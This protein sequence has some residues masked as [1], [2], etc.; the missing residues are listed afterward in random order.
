MSG[1]NGSKAIQKTGKEK[2]WFL[3]WKKEKH[4]RIGI[5]GYGYEK[6]NNL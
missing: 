4:Y 2:K 1:K 3:A 5:G 6:Q